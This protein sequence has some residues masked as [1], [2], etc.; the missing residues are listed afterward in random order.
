MASS[1]SPE[2]N[3]G[4][5]LSIPWGSI[6]ALLANLYIT[7]MIL[8]LAIPLVIIVAVSVTAGDFL[9]F[10]PQGFSL[11]YYSEIL[12]SANWL[13]AIQLSVTV[14]IGS[15]ILAT[16]L[17]GALAFGLN[18][19][20]IRYSKS[21][22]GL[23]VLPI[24]VPPVIIAVG[25]MS[26]FLVIGIWGSPLAIIL[27]HGIVFAPFPFIMISSGLDEIDS[28]VEEAARILGASRSQTIRTITVPLI[29]S[30]VVIGLL[31]VFIISLNEYLIALFVSGPGTETVPIL[32]FSMLRYGYD[33]T[34]AAISVIY[35]VVTIGV[36]LIIDF[37]LDGQLW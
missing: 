5:G 26:F 9:E 18:R 15:S 6:G 4:A 32:I 30:N 27:A 16:T 8:A 29:A 11:Q 37:K 25:L 17:G 13:S 35:M 2:S 24:L 22:W 12:Q 28:S 14:A 10:P 19:Y 1:H 33:P 7:I 20:E 21:I 3:T 34:I 23:A 31:F 36:I